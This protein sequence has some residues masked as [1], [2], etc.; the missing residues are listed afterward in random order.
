MY[1][2]SSK[3][4]QVLQ[5]FTV[6]TP[7]Y[8]KVNRA[9]T[10][11]R[12]AKWCAE[13]ARLAAVPPGGRLLDIAT[14]T[15]PIAFA[16]RKRYPTAEITACDFSESMIEE[17]S[18]RPGAEGITWE[19]ADANALP[20]EDDSFDAITHGYLLRNVDDVEGVLREQYRVLKP[21]GRIAILETCP[22][23][24]ILKLPVSIGVKIIVPT[25]GQVLAKNRASYKYLAQS[26]LDFMT[27]DAV[28]QVMKHIGFV[29]VGWQR[30]FLTTHMLLHAAKPTTS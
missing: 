13:V 1:S 14:G 11:G 20:Y 29:S 28:A 2:A 12:H 8:D 10:L 4:D 21:G 30:R 27:P 17:A 6:V 25:L 15:G 22:P 16:A 3:H 19:I 26:T 24:G 5:T 9:M 7:D 18:S 23:K